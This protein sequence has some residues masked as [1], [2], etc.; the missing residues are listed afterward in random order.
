MNN[1]SQWLFLALFAMLGTGAFVSCTD[2]V[3]EAG[4]LGGLVPKTATEN[5]DLPS[6]HLNGSQ[7]H[8]QTFGTQG[9][10][11]IVFLHGG[12]GGDYKSLL[13]LRERYNGY[14]LADDHFLVFWDQRGS[15]LS[16]RHS[17]P[18]ITLAAYQEDLRQIIQH[19]SP[20]APVLLIGH[21]WGGMYA[22]MFIN[23][24]PE[25][26]RGAV[27]ME[28]GPLTGASFERVKNRVIKL[29]FFAEW[30]N[31]LAWSQQFLAADDHIRWDYSW[32][33]GIKQSQPEYH[34]DMEN[35]P[36]AAW[37]FG[38]AANRYVMEDGSD[39]N[40][41]MTYDFTA[42]KLRSFAPTVLFMASGKN[43]VIGKDFQEQQRHVYSS[44][45]LRVVPDCGHDFQWKKSAE[46]VAIIKQY[47]E[48]L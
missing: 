27:L 3:I 47:I 10:P 13:R 24:Y 5:P 28:A 15:G 20:N 39:G 38:A 9:K 26:V 17:K 37:R 45:I 44:S 41:T 30:L 35:D 40:G 4:E 42:K 1:A 22:T 6:L 12:P 34:Q 46:C 32:L 48:T 43:T 29:N 2:T 8:V 14:S 18:D 21:S 33:L 36:A 25:L 16:Q 7:F 31:D 19:Y 11:V 23:E